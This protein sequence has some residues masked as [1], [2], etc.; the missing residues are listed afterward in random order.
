MCLYL[1]PEAE[2]KIAEEDIICYKA[3][4][5]NI[6]AGER[7]Y[8]SFFQWNP[9]TVGE[10]KQTEIVREKNEVNKGF[11]SLI[12]KETAFSMIGNR[13]YQFVFQC[14]IPK[15]S[16]YYEGKFPLPFPF[17][18]G[19]INCYASNQIIYDKIITD[20]TNE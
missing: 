4:E 3:V 2:I 6:Q 16:E 1:E 15:G 14:R 9:V 11:H 10:I 12:H 17:K 19:K 20:E 13:Y 7:V 5:S 8:F 18:Q